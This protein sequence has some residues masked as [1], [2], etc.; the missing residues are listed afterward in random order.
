MLRTLKQIPR[1][2][3]PGLALLGLTLIFFHGLAF[4]GLILGRGDTYAYFY[5]YWAVRNA[6]LMQGRL[7]L[8]SP[9]IFMGVPLL[10]NPQLGT[11]YP[12]NWPLVPLSPPDGIR[13]TVLM[14]V[15]WSLLGAYA[16]ARRW[17]IG[18]FPAL[19]AAAIFGLGGYTG[20]HVEQINQLQGL[21]WMPWLFWLYDHALRNT[22]RHVPLLAMA[23]ALQFLTGH[24]QTVFISGLGLGVYGL[25]MPMVGEGLRPSPTQT[26]CSSWLGSPLPGILRAI[27]ILVLAG[28]LAVP[29]IL[30]QMIPTME[31]TGVS[32]RGGGL[33]PNEATAFSLHPLIIGRGLLPSYDSIIFGEYVAYGGII[34]LGLAIIGLLIPHN[35]SL[36]GGRIVWGVIGVLG[37]LLALGE[38]N[39]VYWQ[40]AHLPGFSFFRVPARWLALFALGSALLA[41]IGLQYL[42]ESPR[43]LRRIQWAALVLILG[44]L[45]AGSTLAQQ[46][47]QDV[48]GPAVPTPATWLG[49][50]LGAVGL[51]ALIF[52]RRFV[53]NHPNNSDFRRG[54]PVCPPAGRSRRV[55]P[56]TPNEILQVIGPTLLLLE[57]FLAARVLP[58][59]ALVLPEAYEAQ[60]FTISQMIA[61][62]AGQTPPGRL[63]SVTDLLFDPG[64]RAALEARYRQFGFS[65]TQVRISHI[66]TK[67]KEVLAPNLPLIWN[68]SSIDGFDGGLLPTRYYTAFSKLI[69]PPGSLATIDGRL[70]EILAHEGCGGVCFPDRRWLNLTNTR[71]LITD[72][73]FDLWHE[74]VAFDTTFA[75][76]LEAGASIRIENP[77]AFHANAVDALYTGDAPPEVAFLLE[78]RTVGLSP[79]SAKPESLDRYPHLRFQSDEA[80]APQFIEI[81]AVGPV[82][83]RAVSLV[84]TRTGDFV[85]LVPD[86]QWRRLLS[87]DIKLY[88]NQAAMSRAFVVQDVISLPDTDE[89]T[90]A[91]LAVM[92]D[93]AFDPAQTAIIHRN[94]SVGAQRA[95]PLQGQPTATITA[96]TPQRIVIQTQSETEGYLVLT[97]TYYPG[98]QAFV[99]GAA[100]PV[101]RAD[102]LFRAMQVP[103]GASE[104]I[105]EYRPAWLPGAQIAGGV[106]WTLLIVT[107]LW[108]RTRAVPPATDTDQAAP[109][110]QVSSKD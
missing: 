12:P 29:L 109:D 19:A 70:R 100:T 4:S 16:L 44:G 36:S 38:F 92:S 75:V 53:G 3:W 67:L 99:N 85:Q 56:T 25:I 58:Y 5:P 46:S 95:A 61:Y 104:V 51:V 93:P 23:L 39:P 31:L 73:V 97:D 43:G 2:C 74:D 27:L 48:I 20:A 7:P 78:D 33:N 82:I 71:Y 24:T 1:R 106:S 89:G 13:L 14:H 45:A 83:I 50:G 37:L 60:R 101:H 66:A 108:R 72:K 18:P 42:L 84:D 49:W 103:A 79:L 21:A 6:A 110:H 105:F 30:P 86:A 32:N 76:P 98:W 77:A 34:G 8:W 9:D 80:T 107:L 94:S 65:E 47:P 28:A 81:R 52:T 17:Q 11:F 68:V 102:I 63:L 35:Q 87:S 88:E 69:L 26:K 91:A 57:L 10:A 41:G 15:Y 90:A 59:N 40:L 62:G 54:G 96:Y 55:A 22:V 64:D